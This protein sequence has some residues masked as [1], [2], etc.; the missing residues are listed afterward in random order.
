MEEECV[1]V[2]KDGYGTPL[3][4]RGSFCIGRTLEEAKERLEKM[5]GIRN[6]TI[7]KALPLEVF[8]PDEKNYC[9]GF[10]VVY[11]DNGGKKPILEIFAI[12]ENFK[13]A[14]ELKEMFKGRRAEVKK[15]IIVN[16]ETLDRKIV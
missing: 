14:N 4:S 15:L 12:K 5:Q 3:K 9:G 11:E 6:A 10:A 8:I 1:Y 2:A 7:Y 16:S 13:S